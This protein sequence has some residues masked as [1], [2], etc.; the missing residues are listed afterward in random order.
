MSDAYRFPFKIPDVDA[1]L[2]ELYPIEL[3]EDLYDLSTGRRGSWKRKA[4]VDRNSETAPLRELNPAGAYIVHRWLS[5]IRWEELVK[6]I[7]TDGF[8]AGDIMN[9]LFRVAT[10]MQSLGQ[11]GITGVSPYA[12]A[13]RKE[14]LRDPLS[15]NL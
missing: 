1:E 7:A 8:G 10:Y 11:S 2:R 15:L 13:L 14:I 9:V 3:F 12:I 5:G 4:E 6:E